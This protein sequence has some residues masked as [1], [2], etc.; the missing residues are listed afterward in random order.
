MEQMW[1]VTWTHTTVCDLNRKLK[2]GKM[3]INDIISIQ[4]DDP[5]DRESILVYYKYLITPKES[6]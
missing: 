1:R 6:D 5:F 2:D 3:D 4:R